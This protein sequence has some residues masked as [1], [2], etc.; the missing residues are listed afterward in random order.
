MASSFPFYSTEPEPSGPS[1]YHTHPR[2]RIAQDIDMNLRVT[3]TGAGRKECP[4]CF[5]LGQFQ[6]NRALRGHTITAL[7][8]NTPGQQRVATNRKSG[9]PR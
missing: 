4:F 9:H 2:C 7:G 5:L 3:G 8:G 6:V 1:L